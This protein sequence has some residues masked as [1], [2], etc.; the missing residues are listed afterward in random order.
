MIERAAELLG[1]DPARVAVIG[2]IAADVEAARRAGARGVLVPTAAT[3]REEIEA[4]PEVA[5]SL[6]DAVDRLLGAHR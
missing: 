4:A 1:V 3:R 6:V 2:D 5:S